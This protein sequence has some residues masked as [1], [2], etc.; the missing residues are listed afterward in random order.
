MQSDH[1]TH[2]FQSTTFTVQEFQEDS[3]RLRTY[4]QSLADKLNS[5]EEFE[6]D[7]TFSVELTV[8]RTPGRGGG[9]GRNKAGRLGKQTIGRLLKTKRSIIE[10]KN[11]DKLCCAR[12]IVTM[13]ALAD[14]ESPQDPD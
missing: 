10:I 12:A 9:G 13:K 8:V 4:L 6:P 14:A 7:D 2:A 5:N 1:F 11:K 3:S